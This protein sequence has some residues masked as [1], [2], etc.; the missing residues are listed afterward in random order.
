MFKNE[1]TFDRKLI[2]E[3]VLKTVGIR[4]IVIGVLLFFAGIIMY[5]CYNIAVMKQV[6]LLCSAYGLLYAIFMPMV[7]VRN[8]EASGKRLNNGK[9]EKTE[10]LFGD[11]IIMNEGRVHLEF[12]Y[13]QIKKIRETKNLIMLG[14]GKS[15]AILVYKSG[16]TEGTKEDFMKFIQEKIKK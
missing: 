5:P 13:E 9:Q 1:Y 8:V 14:L 10:V 6:V 12:E 2:W 4:M 3:Y 16:F 11:N 7:V 15:S